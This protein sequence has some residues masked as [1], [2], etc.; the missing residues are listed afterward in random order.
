M[1]A[2]DPHG[3]L[4]TIACLL[5]VGGVGAAVYALAVRR[6]WRTLDLTPAGA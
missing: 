3:R 1:R 5:V 6:W 2:L 4:A